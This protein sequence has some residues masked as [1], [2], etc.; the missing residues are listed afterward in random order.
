MRRQITDNGKEDPAKNGKPT[1][2]LKDLVEQWTKMD[3]YRQLLAGP[4]PAKT[5]TGE[6]TA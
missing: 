6:S 2:G 3:Y 4:P 5:P 1:L